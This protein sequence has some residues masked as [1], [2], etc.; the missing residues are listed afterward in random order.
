M[1]RLI[2]YS[3]H[4]SS[5]GRRKPLNVPMQATQETT[6]PGWKSVTS[7]HTH[8]GITYY[9]FGLTRSEYAIPREGRDAIGAS[10]YNCRARINTRGF[11]VQ[12]P[13]Y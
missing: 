9:P 1:Q 10:S 5:Q 11:Y 8:K 6:T 12:A 3:E 7:I 13:Q 4:I 2:S